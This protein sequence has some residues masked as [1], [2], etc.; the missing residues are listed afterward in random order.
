MEYRTEYERDNGGIDDDQ[1]NAWA[2]DGWRIVSVFWEPTRFGTP[3]LSAVLL[4][5]VVEEYHVRYGV[6]AGVP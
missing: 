6:G 3:R 5:R 2:D 4:G 1:L